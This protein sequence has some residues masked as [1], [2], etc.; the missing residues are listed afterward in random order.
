MV[1]S[2]I[3]TLTQLPIGYSETV[4]LTGLPIGYSTYQKL[5]TVGQFWQHGQ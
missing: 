3:V 2:V 1:Y 5:T 4:A